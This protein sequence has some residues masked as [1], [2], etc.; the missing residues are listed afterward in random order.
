[1]VWCR[2]WRLSSDT[3]ASLPDDANQS[4]EKRMKKISSGLTMFYK[5]VFPLIW[6]GFI[7]FFVAAVVIGGAV[8][9][10]PL[11]FLVMPCV[12]AVFGFFL[13]KVLVWDLADEVF[14]CGDSLLIKKGGD[15]ERFPLRN[16]MNVSTSVAVNPRRITL[17]LVRPGRFGPEVSFSPLSNISFVP[18]AKNPVAEDLIVRV[19]QARRERA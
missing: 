13:M 1:M 12:M 15:E 5:K 8:R 11:M 16:I 4:A 14:D 19:D 18:F 2:V 10:D 3:T 9:A 17:R 6:F 7:A